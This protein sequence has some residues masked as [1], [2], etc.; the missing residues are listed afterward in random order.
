MTVIKHLPHKLEIAGTNPAGGTIRA[1]AACLELP[2]KLNKP[3]FTVNDPSDKYGLDVAGF[4]ASVPA[5][6]ADFIRD[7][8]GVVAPAVEAEAEPDA[9]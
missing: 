5:L 7:D 1:R 4:D 2:P 6:I 9:E 3:G 8:I